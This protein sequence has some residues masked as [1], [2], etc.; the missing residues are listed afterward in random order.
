MALLSEV[1]KKLKYFIQSYKFIFSLLPLKDLKHFPGLWKVWWVLA[2]CLLGLMDE[3][4]LIWYLLHNDP[5]GRER[6]KWV[7]GVCVKWN[8]PWDNNCCSS[9]LGLG[10]YHLISLLLCMFEYFHN[11]L[12]HQFLKKVLSHV[13]IFTQRSSTE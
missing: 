13:F 1:R 7:L 5:V 11:K 9:V 6:G 4:A 3:L 2:L 12:K 10:S 8:W